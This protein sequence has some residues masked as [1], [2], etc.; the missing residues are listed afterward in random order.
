M[1]EFDKTLYAQSSHLSFDSLL[2]NL[3]CG[4]INR[5]K[6]ELRSF[7]CAIFCDPVCSSSGLFFHMILLLVINVC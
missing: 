1:T 5:L 4:L 2:S 6:K 3:S 7:V